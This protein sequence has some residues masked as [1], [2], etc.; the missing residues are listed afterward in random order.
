MS[1]DMSERIDLKNDTIFPAIP[2][3]KQMEGYLFDLL[4]FLQQWGVLFAVIAAIVC[5][6]IRYL[7]KIRKNP[8]LVRVWTFFAFGSV[9]IA[10]FFAILPYVIVRFI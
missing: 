3:D 1:N 7:F 2:S 4:S 5:L 6:V 8:Q 10:V 9:F